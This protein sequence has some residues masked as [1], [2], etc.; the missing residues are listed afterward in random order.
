[1]DIAVD[2]TREALLVAAKV[3]VPALAIALLV[4]VVVSSF[5]SATQIHEPTLNLVP[6]I[7]AVVVTVLLL[8]PWMLSVL[9]EYA[10]RV[11]GGGL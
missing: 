2:W 3:A 11:I 5:Q 8:L 7:V 4:G 10:A 1:M 6:K 9:S